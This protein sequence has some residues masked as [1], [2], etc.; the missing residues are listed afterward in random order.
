MT[1]GYVFSGTAFIA[2]LIIG[3]VMG[4]A[5]LVGKFVAYCRFVDS[6]MDSLHKWLDDVLEGCL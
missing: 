2:A 3:A 1:Q 5:W 4:M 6:A